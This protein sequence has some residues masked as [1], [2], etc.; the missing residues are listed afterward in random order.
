MLTPP[1]KHY[2]SRQAPGRWTQTGGARQEGITH[3]AELNY[4]L[5]FASDSHGA[6][7]APAE[8]CWGWA[9]PSEYRAVPTGAVLTFTVTK[10]GHLAGLLKSLEAM[11]SVPVVHRRL[12]I[13]PP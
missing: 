7:G 9:Q 5:P 10:E 13:T 12:P 11:A 2:I 4:P 1:Q 3:T 8:F 6:H